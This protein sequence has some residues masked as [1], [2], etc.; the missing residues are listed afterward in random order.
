MTAVRVAGVGMIPFLQPGHH[1]PY[2]VMA[3]KA[4]RLALTDANLDAKLIEQA[5]GAYIY[6]DSTRPQHAF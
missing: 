6:G 4:I 3:A 1:Q 5:Y 2:R